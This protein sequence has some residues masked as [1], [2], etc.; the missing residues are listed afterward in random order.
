[1]SPDAGSVDAGR[2]AVAVVVLV[3][4][5]PLVWVD[6]VRPAWV[7]LTAG[8]AVTFEFRGR[9]PS[10]QAPTSARMT[11]AAPSTQTLALCRPPGR[12]LP[13]AT[14]RAG[15]TLRLTLRV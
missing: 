4:D 1:M 7:A 11:T 9:P 12:W 5:R 3:V 14:D 2:V 8:V 15:P 13:D 10:A 6:A